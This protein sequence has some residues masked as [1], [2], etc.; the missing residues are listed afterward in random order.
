MWGEP[1]IDPAFLRELTDTLPPLWSTREDE[2]Y[3][4]ERYDDEYYQD[5]LD[6][7]M[8]DEERLER[9]IRMAA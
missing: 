4:D 2:Q 7:P 1:H 9:D 5:D 6:P 3:D 8:S